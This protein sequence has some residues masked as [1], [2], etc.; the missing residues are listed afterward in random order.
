M[1]TISV[2]VFVLVS[3]QCT[4]HRE[5]RELS[6]A[7]K[8]GY[9]RAIK[10]MRNAPSKLP[11]TSS[12]SRWEDFVVTHSTA[13]P[14]IHGTPSFLPWHRA[15]LGI[16]D[17]QMRL[18]GYQGPMPYW[19]WSLDSQ[20]PEESPIWDWFGDS[21]NGCVTMRVVGALS[22]QVPQSHCVR[23]NWVQEPGN[24]L[25]RTFYSPAQIQL[26]MQS[27]TYDEFR[28]A[29]ESIPHNSVHVGIGGDMGV[30]ARSVNDPMFFLHHRNIDR[31]WAKW[32]KRDPNFALAYGGQNPNGAEANLKNPLRFYG[33][34]ANAI[35]RD[36]M[37]TQSKDMPGIACFRYSNSVA[38]KISTTQSLTVSSKVSPETP[39]SKDRT[40]EFK[41][42][43]PPSIPDEFLKSMNYNEKM[44]TQIKAAEALLAEYTKFL[45]Q[46]SVDFPGSLAHLKAAKENGI[47]VKTDEQELGEAELLQYLASE[48]KKKI[49][50]DP[51]A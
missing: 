1:L 11:K 12:A 15:M 24:V 7:E 30:V 3:S 33:L 46:K 44:I 36:F 2:L 10:C 51:G 13:G 40:D 28:I 49:H 17:K 32:Q 14:L 19:D 39:D 26:V 29:L 47:V 18:C 16:F 8:R 20:A 50:F 21:P 5:W 22:S 41:L 4:V 34:H 48:F 31:L 42:R 25:M 9:L 43:V 38:S 27:D 6:T 23:R 35:V 37:D 45:N